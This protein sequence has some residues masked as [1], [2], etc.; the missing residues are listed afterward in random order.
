M[1][2]AVGRLSTSRL[3][4]AVYGTFKSKG[5]VENGV[6]KFNLLWLEVNT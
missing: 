2:E 4:T 1:K 6:K 3:G 5:G